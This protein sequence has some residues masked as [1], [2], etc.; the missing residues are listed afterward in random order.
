MNFLNNLRRLDMFSMGYVTVIL[1]LAS[2]TFFLIGV[3]YPGFI[4]AGAI[5]GAVFFIIP[6]IIIAWMM[7]ERMNT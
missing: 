6:S 3:L 2:L 7:K 1:Y 4:Y 5:L